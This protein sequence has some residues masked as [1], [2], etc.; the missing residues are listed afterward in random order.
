MEKCFRKIIAVTVAELMITMAVLGIIAVIT[1]NGI[2]LINTTEKNW[3]TMSQKMAIS[4]EDASTRILVNNAVLD[5]YLALADG[6]EHF[7]ITDSDAASKMSKL[8]RK[9]LSEVDLNVNTQDEYFSKELTDYDRTS[10]GVK[11]KDIY[12]DFLYVNDGMLMGFRFY[13]SC[14]ASEIYANPPTIKGKIQVDNICGSIFYD[15]NAFKDPNKL[16]SDQYII[17]IYKR[18]VKYNNDDM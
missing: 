9:Y 5:D 10:L 16:G 6:E 18:G 4:I 14:N 3:K 7:S 11:L 17:P 8:Y 2:K 1:V 13:S 15:I 12:S